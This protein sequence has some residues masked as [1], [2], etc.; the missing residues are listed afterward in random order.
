MNFSLSKKEFLKSLQKINK[1]IPHR[2]TLPILSCV[3]LHIKKN[4]LFLRA[5]D[6]EQT[7]LIQIDIN[8]SSEHKLAI[9]A[10]PLLE[11][12]QEIIDENLNININ[13]NNKVEI[14]TDL[15]KYT[16]MGKIANEFPDMP[17]IEKPIKINLD[18]KELIEIIDETL[19]AAS[20][21]EMKLSLQGVCLNV[22]KNKITAVA[23]DGYR[24]VRRINSI[25]ENQFNGQVIIPTKFLN[26]IQSYITTENINLIICTNHIQIENKNITFVSRIIREKYPDYESII[27]SDNN[28]IVKINNQDLLSAV[29]RVSIF[30]N[31][32]T[33]QIALTFEKNTII[34]TTEDS[35]NITSGKEEIIC[36][37]KEEKV[38]IGFNANY[39]RE[40]LTH[41]KS[42]D[43]YI[44]LSS[45]LGAIMIIP[46]KEEN[47]GKEML[48]LL[49]PIRI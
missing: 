17:I 16:I 21:D 46:C 36:D 24:L 12:T 49:M 19:Y 47:K 8:C 25:K 6:L 5:T 45:S 42:N 23:T 28:K 9:P 3:L 44:K 29:K 35:E 13:K 18:K 15:G 2:S 10:K 43:I 34:I 20:K 32:T 27:P 22:E 33:K 11:I 31:R 38:I 40:I 37:Y 7:I 48:S 4:K 30:S 1:V 26:V 41:Q 14:K 39:L